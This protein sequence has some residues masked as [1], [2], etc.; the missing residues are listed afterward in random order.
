MAKYLPKTIVI[1]SLGPVATPGNTK[2]HVELNTERRMKGVIRL[3]QAD[4]QNWRGL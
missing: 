1:V 2:K 3:Q 4:K